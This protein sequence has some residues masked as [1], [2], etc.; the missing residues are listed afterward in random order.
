MERS[1]RPLLYG[2]RPKSRKATLQVVTGP[3]DREAVRHPAGGAALP[4]RR[5][6][7]GSA[8]LLAWCASLPPV[9]GPPPSAPGWPQPRRSLAWMEGEKDGS[10]AAFLHSPLSGRS[11]PDTLFTPSHLVPSFTLSGPRHRA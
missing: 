6:P 5:V 10:P 9:T 7:H 4:D 1:R 8:P 2:E 11:A 3:G